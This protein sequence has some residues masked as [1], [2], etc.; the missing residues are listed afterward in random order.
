MDLR[1]C[2]TEATGRWYWPTGQYH[3]NTWNG[4]YGLSIYDWP[5]SHDRWVYHGHIQTGRWLN[6]TVTADKRKKEHDKRLYDYRDLD[7]IWMIQTWIWYVWYM[8]WLWLWYNDLCYDMNDEDSWTWY[9]IQEY[10]N[11]VVYKHLWEWW[12]WSELFGP[13]INVMLYEWSCL[14]MYN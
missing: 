10:M 8:I 4:T 9:E 5:K 11:T 6:Y 12:L 14:Y 13:G 2:I 3:W 1:V 7:K